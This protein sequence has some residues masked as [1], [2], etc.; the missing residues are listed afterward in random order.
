METTTA[1]LTME[2]LPEAGGLPLV[3]V[4]VPVFNDRP[5]LLLCLGALGRQE[6]AGSFEI[7]VV[8]NG[9]PGDISDLAAEFPGVV[10]VDEPKPGSYNAR[11]AGIARARGSILAFTDADCLPDPA[12]IATGVR[13]LLAN[14]RCGAVGGRVQLVPRDPAN[15]TTAELFDAMF[16][17]PQRGYVQRR[18]FAATANMLSRRE[19]MDVVGSFRGDLRSAGDAEWGQRV[20]AA[21]YVLAYEEAASVRHPAR[22]YEE[23]IKKLR[24]TAAGERDRNPDWG[25]CLRW[26]LQRIGPP[27]LNSIRRVIQSAEF[28]TT[29]GQKIALLWLVVFMRWRTAIE[30]LRLQLVAGESPRS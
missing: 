13:T 6:Y 9:A 25:S 18:H 7:I 28:P 12:W 24:R 23:Q 19:V 4:V 21:G 15:A 1:D 22:D 14:P 3:S 30:R 8:N 10:I 17:I 16:G 29:V 26:S 27:P 2:R 20:F 5:S 11:N